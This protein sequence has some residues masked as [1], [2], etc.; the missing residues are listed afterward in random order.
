MYEQQIP[1]FVDK[2][3]SGWNSLNIP[4]LTRLKK[5]DLGTLWIFENIENADGVE[6]NYQ[7]VKKNNR[8]WVENNFLKISERHYHVSANEGTAGKYLEMRY[9]GESAGIWSLQD[10]KVFHT[11]LALP[12]KMEGVR[13]ADPHGLDRYTPDVKHLS[14]D[15]V[16]KVCRS[17]RQSQETVFPSNY[18][19]DHFK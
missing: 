16:Q 2:N 3:G 8:R 6:P 19:Q 1:Y 12:L 7:Q 13:E 14:R 15:T 5:A 10:R 11:I 9:P 4:S 18:R 17:W